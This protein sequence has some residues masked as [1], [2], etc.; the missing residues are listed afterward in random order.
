MD[1]ND[2]KNTLISSSLG[3]LFARI[4]LHPIDT[5]KT[6]KQASAVPVSS[7]AIVKNVFRTSGGLGFYRGFFVAAAGSIPGVCL[8]MTS[9]EFFKQQ[10]TV[11]PSLPLPLV[12]FVS[13]F[14]AEAFSCVVFVPVDVIKEQLQAFKLAST[15]GAISDLIRKQGVRGLY[16][17]YGATLASFGPFSAFYFLFEGQLS[18]YFGTTLYGTLGCAAV[19]GGFAS[20]I[21]SPLDLVKVRLQLQ[22]PY[23]GTIDGLRTIVKD[24]GF[25]GLMRGAGPRVLFGTLNTAVTLGSI[26]YIRNN[27]VS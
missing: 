4:I 15:T 8:Y 19:S 21:T 25:T 12:N 6:L 23:K 3:G 24:E 22:Y 27:L 9:F 7:A 26:R 14:L 20:L 16:K 1:L 11:F 18:P 5:V 10:L 13:G 17:G 2:L